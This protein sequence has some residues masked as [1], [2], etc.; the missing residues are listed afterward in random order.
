MMLKYEM[1]KLDET[2]RKTLVGLRGVNN[3]AFVNSFIRLLRDY[4]I[5]RRGFE[6]SSERLLFEIGEGWLEVFRLTDLDT[7][8][9]MNMVAANPKDV[10]HYLEYIS[11]DYKKKSGMGLNVEKII[12]EV[13]G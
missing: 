2:H 12:G 4:Y 6:V 10:R 9:L 7:K 1:Y 3:N 8:V 13:V 11:E 5:R